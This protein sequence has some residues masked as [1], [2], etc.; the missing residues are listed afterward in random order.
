MSENDKKD[1][2]IGLI[3]KILEN[4]ELRKQ[5]RNNTQE[6]FKHGDYKSAVQNAVITRMEK[7]GDA[8]S[9]VLNDKHKMEMLSNITPT[10]FKDSILVTDLMRVYQYGFGN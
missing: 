4:K 5:A 7:Q 8:A 10:V 3:D 9:Q 1:F 6:N 2:T